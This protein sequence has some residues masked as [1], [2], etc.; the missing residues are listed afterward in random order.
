MDEVTIKLPHSGKE[1]VIRNYTT[2]KDD[3]KAEELMYVGVNAEQKF[4]EKVKKPDQTI[5]FPVAN[6]AASSRVYLYRLVKSID[7]ETQNLRE[8]IDDLRSADYEAIEE[9]VDK[10]V[11]EHSPKAKKAKSSSKKD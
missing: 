5:K 2:H 4:S 1:V 3:E 9:A 8:V 7:G 10:I 6:I 11:E